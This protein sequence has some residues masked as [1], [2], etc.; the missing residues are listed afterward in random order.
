MPLISVIM[1]VYNGEKYL[2][3]AIYSILDQTFK[4]FEFIII[5]D[6]ST[7]DTER[8]V[9]S[10]NDNRI[11]YFSKPNSGISDSLNV[12]IKKAQGTLI[13]RMDADDIAYPDRFDKQVHAFN[14]DSKLTLCAGSAV[15]IN[16]VGEYLG[17]SF[18]YSRNY[19]IK[20][21][22]NYGNVITHPTVM[23]KRSAILECGGYNERS[24]LYGGEDFDLW[25]RLQNKGKFISLKEPLIYYRIN[26]QS[27]GIET[28]LNNQST[29]LQDE[30]N[31]AKKILDA[32]M[33]Y[34]KRIREVCSKSENIIFEKM[35]K[36]M[37]PLLANMIIEG[38]NILTIFRR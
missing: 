19:A 20:K 29:K 12:G 32:E 18:N 22:L 30:R 2:K 33:A 1:P 24:L 16:E 15:Y 31:I 17:R 9:L 27:L 38:K 14:N 10:L 36:S 25:K 11:K 5:N 6:G 21:M 13:A 37:Q 3:E 23:A 8:I 26:R 28:F 7:D 4:D 35:L 34:L